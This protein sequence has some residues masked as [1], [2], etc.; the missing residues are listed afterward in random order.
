[1]I[2][3]AIGCG[4]SKPSAPRAAAEPDGGGDTCERLV[5]HVETLSGVH[6]SGAGDR[7][8]CRDALTE[9]QRACGLAARTA[10]D[11]NLCV[12]F[13]DPA[14]RARGRTIAASVRA[15]WPGTGEAPPI[16]VGTPG[17]GFFGLVGAPDA[18]LSD[19]D[20]I[21]VFAVRAEGQ[22]G[23]VEPLLVWVHRDTPSAPWA[24]TR[25]D[26]PEQCDAVAKACR[27]R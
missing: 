11:F 25:T 9:E 7:A 19:T 6:V 5:R 12:Q 27:A 13:V 4:G 1:M 3:A 18:P 8:W 17:C 10:D 16:L 21:A 26:P 14:R 15:S 20:A 2:A 24:C 22:E 23:E